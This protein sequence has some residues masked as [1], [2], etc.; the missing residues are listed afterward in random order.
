VQHGIL[1]MH[2]WGAKADNVDLPDRITFDLDPGPKVTWVK[3]R[4]AA[5]AIRGLLHDRGLE[6]WLKTSGGKGLHVVVPIE[7][8]ASWEEVGKFARAVAERLASEDPAGFVSKM[9]KA[10]RQGRIFIDWLRNARGASAVAAW[11]TR[12]RP[13]APISMPWPWSRIDDLES[14]DQ[15]T[16][17]TVLDGRL[18]RTDPWAGL[19]KARQRLGATLTRA[20]AAAKR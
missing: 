7:R 17:A 3:V 8:R 6:S 2:V 13:G 10:S 12:A 14:G 5:S 20:L 4:A 18:P 1:E 16:V 11:S 15:F 9:A 19:L